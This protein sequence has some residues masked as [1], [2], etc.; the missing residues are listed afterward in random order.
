MTNMFKKIIV[1]TFVLILAGC[2]RGTIKGSGNVKTVDNS[3]A[4]F[5]KVT[6]YGGLDISIVPGDKY[7]VQVTTDDNLH[8]YLKVNLTDKLLEIGPKANYKLDPTT[9]VKV[10][11]TTDTLYKLA[12]AGSV[13]VNIHDL[14][15]KALEFN[16]AG[17]TDLIAS[18]LQLDALS[19]KSTGSANLKLSGSLN[20]GNFNLAGSTNIDAS[21]LEAKSLTLKAAGSTN[22]KIYVSDSLT[23]KVAGSSKVSYYGNPRKITIVNNGS[24]TVKSGD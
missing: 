21:K 16:I 9:A 2:D 14:K 13:D 8:Q 10:L 12:T 5:N 3:L 4:M 1:I 23:A 7:S 20:K 24:G 15:S 11:I 17:S 19:V 6:V 22:A 18:N